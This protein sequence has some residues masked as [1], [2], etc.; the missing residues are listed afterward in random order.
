MIIGS[1]THCLYRKG[2]GWLAQVLQPVHLCYERG[3]GRGRREGGSLVVVAR[4]RPPAS[5]LPKRPIQLFQIIVHTRWTVSWQT[6]R[7]CFQIADYKDIGC[8]F[9]FMYMPAKTPNVDAS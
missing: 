7:Q 4:P 6:M 9:V 1:L 2:W 8:N 3:E 5:P